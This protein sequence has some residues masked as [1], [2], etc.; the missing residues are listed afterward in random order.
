LRRSGVPKQ[1]ESNW[2]RTLVSVATSDSLIFGG[3]TALSTVGLSSFS[4]GLKSGRY[5]SAVSLFQCGR[6]PFAFTHQ[7]VSPMTSLAYI[8]TYLLYRMMSLTY[9]SI[10]VQSSQGRDE[11]CQR[12]CLQTVSA[13]CLAIA[14]VLCRPCYVRVFIMCDLCSHFPNSENFDKG[15][16]ASLPSSGAS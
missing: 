6:L 2:P 11:G 15:Y 9:V 8:L 10:C 12:L 4:D 5:T 3:R 13:L 16:K 7:I 1:C 14:V